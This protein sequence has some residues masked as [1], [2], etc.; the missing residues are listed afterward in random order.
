MA[1]NRVIYQSQALFIAP[2][3]T[4]V[5]VSGTTGPNVGIN[6]TSIVN[7][8]GT[9]ELASGISLLKKMDRIQSCNFNF[10]INRQDI[11]EFGKLARIDSIVMETPTVGLDFSY[12]VTDGYNERLMGFNIT[13]FKS[14]G[15][16]FID[17][18]IANGAQAIS[19]LLSDLQGNNYYILTVDEGEDVVGG[20]LTPSST[21]V[22]LGNGF[23][24]EYGFEASVGAI[25]TASIT[26]EAFNIKS[27]ASEAPLTL[28]SQSIGTADANI[29][30]ITGASPAVD[31]FAN[32]AT[33]LTNV[34]NAYKLDYSR[35]FI[36][37]A[38]NSVPGVNFTGFTTGS[39]TVSALR[40]G[41]IQLTLPSSEGLTNLST[42]HIQS[43]SFTLPLSRTVLQRL[44]NTFGFAR[45][46]DVPINMDLNLSAI[47]SELRDENLFDVL[48]SPTK[49]DFTIALKDSSGN[50]KIAYTIKGA[51][52][53]SETYSENLG[54]NQTVDLTYTVQIGGAND[55]TAGLFMSGSYANSLD[56]I[57]SGFF[58][59]GTGK[60][61]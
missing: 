22:G 35:D 20:T 49:Q 23:I 28:T 2:S 43:F 4:G 10:T 29:V 9:G 27:D 36:N 54:D 44:G 30:T 3:S 51:I 24:S 59:L 33:K 39:S 58:K 56:S 12:Y 26:V 50:R 37:A 32:P 6:L 42:A 31:L 11:N 55:T 52:L 19:G 46:I 16:T 38:I 45:V 7:P 14:D 13:G 18:N 47:V 41:D 5:Q 40:P 8:S 57:T 15:S 34:K 61:G 53:Q 17:T 1:R 60:L 48:A 21:I 25:P